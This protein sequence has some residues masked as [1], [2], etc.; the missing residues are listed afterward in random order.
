MNSPISRIVTPAR[1]IF[2]VSMEINEG[3]E[4]VRYVLENCSPIYWHNY[5][6]KPH[7][8]VWLWNLRNMINIIEKVFYV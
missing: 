2:N 3:N 5:F 6:N 8:V 1:S 4:N 7:Y